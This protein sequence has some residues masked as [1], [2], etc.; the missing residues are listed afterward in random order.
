LLFPLSLTSL[1][2]SVSLPT[3]PLSLSPSLLNEK[4]K[5]VH[6]KCFYKNDGTLFDFK[7]AGVTQLAER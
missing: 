4:E 2:L 5:G 6:Q 3:T 7:T 1:S